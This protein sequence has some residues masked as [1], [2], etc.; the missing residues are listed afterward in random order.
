MMYTA[1]ASQTKVIAAGFMIMGVF[2]M[3]SMIAVIMLIKDNSHLRHE[4]K[5]VVTPMGYNAPFAVSDNAASPSYLQMY[6]VAALAMRLNVSPGT[7]NE[8]HQLLLSLFKPGAQPEMKVKLAGEAKQI[9]QNDVDSNF[10]ATSIRVYP[11]AAQIDIRGQL[12][13]WIGSGKPNKEFKHYAMKYDHVD[14]H[15]WLTRFTE[16]EDEK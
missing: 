11:A 14:G 13:T 7:I 12:S 15:T 3:L 6:A 8:Q 1:K 16:V 4:Q 5:V 2:L 10:I 9:I